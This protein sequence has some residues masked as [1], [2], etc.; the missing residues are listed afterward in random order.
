MK[1]II[2]S[3]IVCA[4]AGLVSVNSVASIYKVL[5]GTET[6][7]P[8]SDVSAGVVSVDVRVAGSLGN[9]LVKVVSQWSDVK[10]L[11]ITGSLNSDDM[12]L[13]SRMTQMTKLDL[14]GTDITTIG[15]CEGLTLLKTI[16]LPTTVSSVES[17]A[18]Y[19]CTALSSIELPNVVEVGNVAFAECSALTSISLPKATVLG[20][21]VFADCS[22]LVSVSIPAVEEIPS[23]CFGYC[24][25]LASIDLSNVKSFEGNEYDGGSQFYNCTS[26]TKVELPEGITFI[27]NRCFYDC[28]SLSEI[29]FPFTLTDIGDD[30]F[31]G[32]ALTTAILPEGLKTI[33]FAAFSDAN[34]TT[35]SIPSTI[36]SIVD[37]AFDCYSSKY[38]SSTG[39]YDY[40]TTITDVYCYAVVPLETSV[41]NNDWFSSATLHVPTFSVT[42]YRLDDNWYR[43]GSTV[44][45]DMDITELNINGEF[46]IYEY[47][48]LADKID[49]TINSNSSSDKTGHL[50]VNAESKLSLGKF[51]Q[52]EDIYSYD[53][54]YVYDEY[55]DYVYKYTYPYCSTLVAENEIT[56]DSVELRFKV[57]ENEWNF[58]SF[59]FDV[60]VS[61]IVMPEGTL[62]VVRKYSGENRANMSGDTWQNVTDGMV[63]NAYE[64][65]ILHCTNEES[66]KIEMVVRAVDNANKNK[67]FAHED[68]TMMLKEYASEYAHNRSWNLVGNPY[69]SYYDIQSMEVNTPIT[70]WNGYGYTAYSI[71][72][73]DYILRPNEAFF[74]QCPEGNTA[75]L[76]HKDGRSHDYSIGTS[77][78]ETRSLNVLN[79]NAERSVLN[80]ILSGNGHSDKT[81]LVINEK[82]KADYEINCDASKFMSS[83]QEVPQIYVVDGGL[84]YAI[85][86]RPMGEG[87][88]VL[89]THFGEDGNYMLNLAVKNFDGKVMLT[90][91]ETG[92]TTELSAE[93]YSFR[94][95]DGTDDNRFVVRL[96]K[97]AS[98]VSEI[99]E[100]KQ[101]DGAVY[102]IK[103]QRVGDDAEGLLIKNGKKVIK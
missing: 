14:S 76:F 81:R 20:G 50:T 67:V 8:L 4:C 40:T 96:I 80:F 74:V 2:F 54:D 97:E 53:Y 34:L 65:Y 83:K 102:N 6:Y 87:S 31:Y 19:G 48:G 63:M 71:L 57:K 55:G 98:D 79:N 1:K 64:G 90:D 68:V 43:F 77:S 99:G 39:D 13:F 61:D 35:I 84:K 22:S 49:L 66:D 86:E 38:N 12:E 3:A 60:N 30:A 72:D 37:N 93:N 23:N 15:G 94:A 28:T 42:S 70:I 82:A 41:F 36:E 69:P 52:Y 73:D 24:I 27:P 91:N 5:N 95:T 11:T 62:W 46:A 58:I 44:A 56:A 100:D 18:F 88:Y 78:L 89:G 9:E 51:T 103:G 59:P 92:V 16:L 25:S 101:I 7:R 85:D 45:I 75:M 17:S 10:E 47:A 33:G 32:T 21:G 26:L 29:N